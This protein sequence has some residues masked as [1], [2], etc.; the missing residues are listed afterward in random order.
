MTKQNQTPPNR[1]PQQPSPKMRKPSNREKKPAGFIANLSTTFFVILMIIFLY[2]FIVEQKKNVD[3]IA[4]S[5]LAQDIRA[6]KV[7]E[8]VVSGDKI[9]AVYERVQRPKPQRQL[10]RKVMRRCLILWQIM[11]SRRTSSLL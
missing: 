9:D 2:T 5:Q 8:I 7:S 6:G 11:E 3:E 4:L 10:K 1:G